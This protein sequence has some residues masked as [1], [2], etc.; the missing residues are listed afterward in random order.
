MGRSRQGMTNFLVAL[1]ALAL[2]TGCSDSAD[3]G[4]AVTASSSAATAA[5][6]VSE[7]SPATSS[8]TSSEPIPVG[9]DVTTTV[10]A[11]GEPP[12][13]VDTSACAQ[14]STVDDPIN[15]T[16][17]IGSVAPQSGGLV[18]AVY[19]PVV[20][21]FRAYIDQANEQQQLGDLHLQL[22]VADDAGNPATT[23]VAVEGLLAAGASVI[24][25]IIGSANN[26]AVRD[27]LNMQC[28]PQLMALGNSATFGDVGAAPFTLG[29]LVPVTVET[30]VY[31]NSMVGS[32]GQNGTVALVVTDDAA[33]QEYA[34]AFTDAAAQAQLAIVDQPVVAA[35]A[36]E[37]P[38]AAVL[39]LASKR[40]QTIA[41]ALE[42]AAC[43]T[44]LTE[45][46]KARSASPGWTPLIYISGAC[47]DASILGLAGDAADG[48]LTSANL[49]VDGDFSALMQDRGV[50]DGFELAAE[51][52]T[53]AELTVAAIQQAQAAGVLTRASIVDAAR[54][55]SYRPSLG[56]PGVEYV[57]RGAV[58]PFAAESLQMIRF[59]AG[60][61][62]FV[63]VGPLVT[64]FE[65]S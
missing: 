15:G 24:S 51:G 12:W 40:P 54:N 19:A 4:S 1:V 46:A 35:N 27:M 32:I 17:T 39:V 7:P 47:A 65:S 13:H 14:P 9:T 23:G 26:L 37:P 58:D 25:G 34:K 44:F 41:V 10:E 42:G 3:R 55:L 30:K 57:T 28:V 16:L 8:I 5:A 59:D 56:R 60:N 22:V 43:A 18:S 45:L 53:A 63:D 64:Q 52:W 21:G 38:S 29:G 2:V 6:V 31:A 62:S 36:I 50:H 49:A 33:G 61:R 11:P 48:V 20:E